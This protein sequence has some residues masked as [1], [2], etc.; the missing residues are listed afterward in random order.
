MYDIYSEHTKDEVGHARGDLEYSARFVGKLLNRK[1]NS[2]IVGII[3]MLHL[4]YLSKNAS[5]MVYLSLS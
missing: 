4:W 5:L 2:L 3:M 1:E